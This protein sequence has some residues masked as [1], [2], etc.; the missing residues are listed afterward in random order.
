MTKLA[1]LICTLPEPFY[2]RKLKRLLSILD[3]QIERFNGDVSYHIH[4]AGRSMKTGTK[5]N[6]LIENT[7]SEYFVFID[8]DDVVTSTY[9][10]DIMS[11][12]K[13]NP[14]VVTIKGWMTT[15]GANRKEWTIKLG[16]PYTE[17]NGHY[18]RWP[19][20]LAVMK[21]SLV[22]HIKFPDITQQEDFHWS[23]RINDLRLLKTEIHI[24]KPT[25]HY[26]FISPKNRR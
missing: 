4:D 20:H 10:S 5:R 14:D 1:I 11:A 7:E 26:D 16:S 2:I 21:R 9:V 6:L 17:R 8:S 12:L 3:P 22:H 25:Y 18:Y 19:N 15:D 24:D 23:K 13:H